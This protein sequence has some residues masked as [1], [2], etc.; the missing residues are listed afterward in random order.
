MQIMT[1][2]RILIFAGVRRTVRP[3]KPIYWTRRGLVM[4]GN[5]I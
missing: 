5:S 3:A 4:W 1:N 2:N